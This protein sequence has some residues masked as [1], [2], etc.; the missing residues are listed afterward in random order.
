MDP[1]AS[2][3]VTKAYQTFCW[4]SVFRIFKNILLFW[5][6]SFEGKQEQKDVGF[7]DRVR[8]S[9]EIKLEENIKTVNT[10]NITF[11]Y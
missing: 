3:T 7:E 2:L 11:N 1:K 10:Q 8:S 5:V 4:W 6:I 9:P